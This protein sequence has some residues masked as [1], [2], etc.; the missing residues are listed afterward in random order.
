MLEGIEVLA[1]SL[2]DS[3][4]GEQVVVLFAGETEEP[5]VKQA[6]KD[7]KLNPLMIP[8][9]LVSVA[10]IPKLGSGKSDFRQAKL[11]AGEAV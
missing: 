9:R 10:A 11:L 6:I 7:A 4:K 5:V 8:S 2:P 1:T 3:R